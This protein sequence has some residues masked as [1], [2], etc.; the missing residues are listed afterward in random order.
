MAFVRTWMSVR[1]RLPTTQT[2][3]TAIRAH[4]G[5]TAPNSSTN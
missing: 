3:N 1:V 2:P 4:K 5:F